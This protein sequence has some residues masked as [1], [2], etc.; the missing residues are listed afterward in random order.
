MDNNKKSKEIEPNDNNLRYRSMY[1]NQIDN[2]LK[3]LIKPRFLGSIHLEK[4]TNN[5]ITQIDNFIKT[6]HQL[7]L[8]KSIK[9]SIFNPF[10]KFLI[11]IIIVFNVLWFSFRL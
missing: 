1:S 9:N 6:E 11:V 5:N 10:T 2:I 7:K 4:Q 3:N 8:K